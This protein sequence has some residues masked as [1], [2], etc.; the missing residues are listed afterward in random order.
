MDSK[1][2]VI[3]RLKS[4]KIR[5][6]FSEGGAWIY[7]ILHLMYMFLFAVKNKKSK[8]QQNQSQ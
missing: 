5:E 8:K 6:N 2:N 7:K 4:T 3:L 1:S